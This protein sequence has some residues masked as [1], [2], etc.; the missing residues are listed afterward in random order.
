MQLGGDEDVEVEGQRRS[1][2]DELVDA[3]GADAVRLYILFIGPADQDMEWTEEGDRG[4]ARFVRRLWRIVHEV[5]ERRRRASDGGGALARKAHETIAKVTDDIGRR[6]AFNTPI[7]AVMELVN[8]LSRDPTAPGARFAAETAVSLIQPYAPHVAEELWERLGHE[9][10]WEQPWPVADESLLERETFELV[11]QVNGK[12]RDRFEARRRAPE[13]RAGRAGARLAAGAGA[14]G[15]QARSGRRSSCRASSSTSSSSAPSRLSARSASPTR[16]SLPGTRRR[17]AGVPRSSGGALLLAAAAR[18]RCSC[19]RAASLL[20]AGHDHG[21]AH[22]SPAAGRRPRA[23]PAPPR[24]SSSTS[25]APCAGRASTGCA[26]GSRIAD[27]VARA[28][29]A[30]AQGRARSVNLAAPLADGEQVVVPGAAAPAAAGGATGAA[31][32][33]RRPPRRS[34]SARRRSSSSTRCRASGR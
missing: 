18:S 19:S 13:E 2:P 3:Y 25:S 11:V 31:P 23:W 6:F 1:A 22:S 9:R 7:A 4:D 21:G 34:T 24:G 33:T 29:G 12:V 14:P 27:A 16:D 20:G 28:G 15:R 5:A 26:H 30:T 8:E 10:L 32:A 17:H